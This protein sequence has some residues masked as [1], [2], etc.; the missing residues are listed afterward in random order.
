VHVVLST[1]GCCGDVEPLAGLARRSKA[2]EAFNVFDA[3]EV[4]A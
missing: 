3:A 4:I 1:D 2:L